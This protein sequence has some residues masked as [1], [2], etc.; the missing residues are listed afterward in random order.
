MYFIVAY[1]EDE[2]N[3]C[4]TTRARLKPIVQ[5]KVGFLLTLPST[6]YFTCVS[7]LESVRR[8]KFVLKLASLKYHVDE[9][10]F[11]LMVTLSARG[12]LKH[13]T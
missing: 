8:F 13:H 1:T 10:S 2:I 11:N 9:V 3:L 7:C 4:F 6:N 12:K 5:W